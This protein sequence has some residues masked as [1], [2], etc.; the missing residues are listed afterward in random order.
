MK[1]NHYTN[2]SYADMENEIDQILKDT[3]QY[4]FIQTLKKVHIDFLSEQK[5]ITHS[6]RKFSFFEKKITSFNNLRNYYI[7]IAAAIAILLAIGF[8]L[9]YIIFTPSSINEKIF[10]TYY[11]AYP[12]TLQV[13]SI[14]ESNTIY[15]ALQYYDNKEY[16]KSI[17][18][19]TE[20]EKN[21][22]EYALIAS[23]FK[24]IACI[25]IADYKNAIQALSKVSQTS[26]NS[27]TGASH[28]YLSLTWIKLNNLAKAKEHLKWLI[29]ND[30]YYSSKA[31]KILNEISP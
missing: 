14:V 12:N 27:Y 25:E 8:L 15:E 4:Q 24:G 6:Q 13:R 10:M 22:P 20:I 7:A 3:E 23:F 28:W 5:K 1:T 17:A 18:L 30:R 21:N 26:N 9:K 19:F 31:K 2:I 16:F 29:E 11:Q